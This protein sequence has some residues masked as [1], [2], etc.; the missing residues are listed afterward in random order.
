MAAPAHG[1]RTPAP[2]PP[3]LL[4]PDGRPYRPGVGVMLR[5]NERRILVGRRI[6]MPSANPWQ[7]PQGGLD[8]GEAADD[9][10]WRELREEIGTDRADLVTRARE[11]LPY[12][13]PAELGTEVWGGKYAGQ[14]Q[15]W[16]LL[17]FRG[18]GDDIVLGTHDAEFAEVSWVEPEE[19]PALVVG[20]KRAVYRA[21]LDEFAPFL[22][23]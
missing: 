15:M 2:P 8:A 20:F 14:L 7:M 22:A 19:L 16:Y 6:D 13:F 3:A 4:G 23:P 18:T 11:W 17:H 21:V 1:L 12:D 10:L 5:D 9:A